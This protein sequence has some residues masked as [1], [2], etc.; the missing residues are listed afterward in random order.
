MS[1]VTGTSRTVAWPRVHQESGERT[2]SPVGCRNDKAL[3][4]RTA[5]SS[6]HRETAGGQLFLR[7]GIVFRIYY[8]FALK[9]FFGRIVPDLEVSQLALGLVP[10]F[11]TSRLQKLNP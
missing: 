8:Y 2:P 1:S 11:D 5:A 6:S 3:W 4:V 10:I 9:H 7:S